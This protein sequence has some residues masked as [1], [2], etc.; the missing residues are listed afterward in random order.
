MLNKNEI[1]E[2]A[3]TFLEEMNPSSWDG[4]GNVPVGFDQCTMGF[5]LDGVLVNYKYVRLDISF[6]LCEEDDGTFQ[7]NHYCEIVYAD[8]DEVV[9]CAHGYGIN[10]EQ[11]LVDTI[12]TL[13]ES[14]FDR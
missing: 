8:T 3:H 1:R 14:N 12:T 7:W 6:E 9:D 5:P 10:S 4:I 11:N 2:I 13:L